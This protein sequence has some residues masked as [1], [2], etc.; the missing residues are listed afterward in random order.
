MVLS[1]V[2]LSP[3]QLALSGDILIVT[4]WG[5]GGHHWC[6][7]S[8]GQGYHSTP[9]SDLTQQK[10][11]PGTSL[12][13]QRLRLCASTWGAQVWPLIRDRGTWQAT[14]IGSQRVGGDWSD[15]ARMRTGERRGFPGGTSGKEI[16]CQCR[17]FRFNPW[18]WKI[19]W[20]REWQL[21]PV[22][23]PGE[24]H[25]QRSLAGYSLW[26]RKELDTTERLRFHFHVWPIV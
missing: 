18:V 26:G 12:V 21:T 11:N 2:I 3:K 24:F 25:G 23:L 13:V 22:F 10:Q 16:S 4:V 15:L 19:P 5:E 14:V 1:G 8:G 17:R 9:D 6:L 7:V 20:R